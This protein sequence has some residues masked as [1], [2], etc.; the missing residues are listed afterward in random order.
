LVNAST[1]ASGFR[2]NVD[3]Y[4]IIIFHSVSFGVV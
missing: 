3:K 2:S 4:R 1:A